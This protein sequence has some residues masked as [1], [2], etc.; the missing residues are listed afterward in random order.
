MSSKKAVITLHGIRT[1]G[2]WQKDLDTQLAAGDMVPYPLDYRYGLGAYLVPFWREET[3]RW[4]R[5]QY[6]RVI[7]AAGVKRPSII[8]HSFGTYLTAEVLR[9]YPEVK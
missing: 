6:D 7:Q 2:K 5:D 4:L 8:A 1:H 3:I 9:R